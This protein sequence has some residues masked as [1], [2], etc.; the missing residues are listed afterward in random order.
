MSSIYKNGIFVWNRLNLFISDIIA[1]LIFPFYDSVPSLDD[2]QNSSQILFSLCCPYTVKPNTPKIIRN[3]FN[4]PRSII[5]YQIGKW[6][7]SI[8]RN[9]SIHAKYINHMA[10]ISNTLRNLNLIWGITLSVY[11]PNTFRIPFNIH[12]FSYTQFIEMML[13]MNF[14]SLGMFKFWKIY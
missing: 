6:I 13:K 10:I 11:S 4:I 3:S 14:K 1:L 9:I 2:I 12:S 8:K 7:V 5:N